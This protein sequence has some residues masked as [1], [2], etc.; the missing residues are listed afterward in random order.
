LRLRKWS[1]SQKLAPQWMTPAV[2]GVALGCVGLLALLTTGS[3]SVFGV[4]YEQLSIELQGS[5]PLKVLLI[6]CV[7][8]LAGTV[9]SYGSGSS[10]GIFGPALY[11]GGMLGGALGLATRLLLHSTPIQPG[12]FALVG[13]GAVFAGIVRAPV[14]SIIM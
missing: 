9:I 6:L 7:C 10:G 5:L 1:Q 13:M 3:A 4:G 8:K 2:G 12:A 11:I 14:T